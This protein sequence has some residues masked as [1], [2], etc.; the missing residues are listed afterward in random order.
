MNCF[1]NQINLV[2][3]SF[4]CQASFC[5]ELKKE[6]QFIMDCNCASTK[7]VRNLDSTTSSGNPLYGS[8]GTSS[9]Y[10]YGSRKPGLQ[11]EQERETYYR[12]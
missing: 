7:P 3:I 4:V 5:D 8:Y 10:E 11:R 1:A 6:V 9:T 12:K 2:I